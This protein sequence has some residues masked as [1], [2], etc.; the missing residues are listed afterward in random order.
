MLGNFVQWAA[1]V[2]LELSPQHFWCDAIDPLTGCPLVSCWML[3]LA[4]AI[5]LGNGSLCHPLERCRQQMM[6][7]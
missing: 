3:M 2:C 7:V 4:A 6:R 1:A 5:K